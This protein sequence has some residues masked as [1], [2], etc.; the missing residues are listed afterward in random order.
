MLAAFLTG[1]ISEETKREWRDALKDLRG[2]NMQMKSDKDGP[3]Q[4]K[5]DD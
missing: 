1:C 2:D 5:R 3:E 4:S